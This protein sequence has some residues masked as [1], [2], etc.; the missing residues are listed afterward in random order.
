[1]AERFL[2]ARLAA[3]THPIVMFAAT[4]PLTPMKAAT[5]K[6]SV[7][8]PA[9]AW[10]L[11]AERCRVAAPVDLIHPAAMTVETASSMAVKNATAPS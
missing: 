3:T 9:K 4:A 6:A 1:M 8:Q 5:G 2:A 11:T 10:A 7:A